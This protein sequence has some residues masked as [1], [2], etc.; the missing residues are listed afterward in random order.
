M[1]LVASRKLNGL[2]SMRWALTYRLT[3]RGSVHAYWRSAHPN[4][5]KLNEKLTQRQSFIDTVPPAA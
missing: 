2:R 4:L 1:F 5:A 3:S